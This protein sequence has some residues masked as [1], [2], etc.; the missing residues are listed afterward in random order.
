MSIPQFSV[1]GRPDVHIHILAYCSSPFPIFPHT[2]LTRV[3]DIYRYSFHSCGC[4]CYTC[5]YTTVRCVFSTLSY[6]YL[7]SLYYILSSMRC[8]HC[9]DSLMYSLIVPTASKCAI[10]SIRCR[11]IQGL[12]QVRSRNVDC[13][14]VLFGGAS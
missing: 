8:M 10:L 12:P 7:Y 11:C 1:S 2:L 6:Y 13:D 9:N 14:A 4:C 5:L 3:H